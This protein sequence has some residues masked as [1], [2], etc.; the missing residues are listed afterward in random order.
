MTRSDL[1]NFVLFIIALVF[2]L[3]V[4]G[5]TAVVPK[6]SPAPVSETQVTACPPDAWAA[7]ERLDYELPVVDGEWK[8][9]CVSVESQYPADLPD[10]EFTIQSWENPGTF[11]VYRYTV[12]QRA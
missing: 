3:I 11:Y 10:N 9:E 4:F 7:Y 12:V 8:V 2:V 6:E 5:H 1:W